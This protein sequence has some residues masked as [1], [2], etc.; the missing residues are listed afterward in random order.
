MDRTLE[1]GSDDD[2]ERLDV[3]LVR[4]IPEL[5]R[6]RARSLFEAGRVRADGR[7]VKKS[8]RV[9]AGEVV[10]VAGPLASV[11][12]VAIPD[13]ETKLAVVAETP[14][15]VVVD[16]PV[17]MPSHPLQAG[18]SGT[19]ANVL[20]ARYPEMRGIGYRRRE[21]GIVHRLDN[22]TSGL[23]LAARHVRAFEE[24]LTLLRA[25]AIEKH[26][27]ATCVGRVGVPLVIDTPLAADPTDPR[28]MIAVADPREVKRLRAR[29]AR[30]EVLESAPASDRSRILV[31][32]DRA[33]RHQIRAHMSS[34]GHPLLGDELYGAPPHADGHHHLRAARLRFRYQGRDIDVVG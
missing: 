31:R 26:Y 20:V 33:R 19:V 17:G 7:I 4:R 25:G 16:K 6:D 3:V 11:D 14:D 22:D 18:E 28:R 12:F 15:F 29:S 1:L 34:V 5:S 8:H 30:T 24:L 23:L 9:S 13:S 21:P 2:G 10:T 27:R 32:A